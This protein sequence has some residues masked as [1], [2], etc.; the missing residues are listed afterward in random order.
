MISVCIATYNGSKFIEQQLRSI[1]NQLEQNDEVIVSDDGSDDDTLAIVKGM[2]DGRI[3]TI[4]NKRQ[5][6]PMS[7]F[8]NALRAAKGNYIFLADQD[9]VWREDKVSVCM[10][11]LKTYDCVIS[12]AAM[13]DAEL[14]ITDNSYFNVH[15]TRSS[16]L[17]NL[18]I[19]NGYMGCC[20]AFTR[21]VLDAA[22]PFPSNVA[23]HDIWIGNVAAFKFSVKFIPEKLVLYR[24]HKTNSS[25]TARKK[26]G[27]SPLK[28]LTIRRNT[29]REIIKLKIRK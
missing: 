17:Y 14:N 15:G 12:D 29:I 28:M 21:R 1:L 3:K 16:R 2:A 26:S 24:C 22:L 5:H 27:N 19:K 23:L 6:S 25:F 18:F 8:E 9:D 10:K 13:T 7:N 20:M 4:R 11:W